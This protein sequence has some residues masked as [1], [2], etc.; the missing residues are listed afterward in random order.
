ML[1]GSPTVD[2][3]LNSIV[4]RL[5]ARAQASG[6]VAPDGGMAVLDDPIA[7]DEVLKSPDRFRKNYSL[8][9]VLGSSRFTANG[10]EWEHR[11]GLTQPSYALAAHSR[12]RDAIRAVYEARLGN[13]E[14]ATPAAIQQ[15]LLGAAV[16][17]FCNALG[18]AADAEALLGFFG[19]VR[20]ILKAAQYFS[21]VGSGDSDRARLAAQ[22]GAALAEYGAEVERSPDLVELMARFRR[23]AAAIPGFS[24]HEEL[25]MNF[26]AGIET[27]AATLCWAIT[28]L[29]ADPRVQDRVHQ[30]VLRDMDS[31]PYLDC[32]L[33]ETMRYFPAV[34]FVIREVASATRLGSIELP[35]KSLVLLSIIGVHHH[36]DYWK[37]PH[38]FDT[39]RAEFLENRYDRRAFIPFLTG[40]RMCGGARL[41]RLELTEGLKVFVRRFSVTRRSN[42]F[43]FD[44]GLALRPNSWRHIEIRQRAG[45]GARSHHPR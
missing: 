43:S 14:S 35:A 12:N 29:G 2:A 18:C 32:F 31:H 19:R 22:A 38:V 20:P 36:R 8:L 44:Y 4:H 13:C 10:A 9:S 15:G 25:L 21:W 28:C 3:F 30:E 39:A 24:P 41:A 23:E 17:V 33:N 1:A 40:P 16:T 26:F 6:P 45:I 27:S 37:E 7:V 42:E 5:Y 11:R 34:P